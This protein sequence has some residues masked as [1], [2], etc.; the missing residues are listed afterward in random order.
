MTNKACWAFLFLLAGGASLLA[1]APKD[2]TRKTPPPGSPVGK[3]LQPGTVVLPDGTRLVP[4]GQPALGSGGQSVPR[5]NPN[6]L[7]WGAQKAPGQ[8]AGPTYLMVPGSQDAVGK[9]PAQLPGQ[10]VKTPTV[11]LTDRTTIPDQGEVAVGAGAWGADQ[12]AAIGKIPKKAPKGSAPDPRDEALQAQAE[13]MEQQRKEF[14]ALISEMQGAVNRIGTQGGDK[15]ALTVDPELALIQAQVN[16]RTGQPRQ[17]ASEIA[18]NYGLAMIPAGTVLHLRNVTRV[19]TQLGGTCLAIVEQDVWD[20]Q[21]RAIVLP[22]GTRA[23]GLIQQVGGDAQSRAAIVFRQLVDPN[24]DQVQLM[25]QEP[26]ANSIGMS[27]LEGR[28]NNHFGVKFGS[29]LVWGLLSGLAGSGSNSP[30]APG[31]NFGDVV[32]GNVAGSFGQVGQ[33]Y[34]QRMTDIKS[35]IEVAENTP[36]KVVLGGPIYLKPWREIRPF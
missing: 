35:D 32:Q 36:M 14:A 5:G 25:V 7:I 15:D 11:D 23:L 17:R 12:Q 29:A 10:V 27:G 33:S 28:V 6:D 3:V 30:Q 31:S 9:A 1:Q 26:A 8:G 19:Q 34:L 20:S 21:M 13:L 22:R 4:A 2:I 18:R 24:G 16:P